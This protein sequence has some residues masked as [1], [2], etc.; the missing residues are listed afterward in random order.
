MAQGSTTTPPKSI[1]M[2]L[3][4]GHAAQV[5]AAVLQN[6]T[7]DGRREGKVELMKMAR[8]ADLAIEQEKVIGQMQARITN[9][10]LRNRLA[11]EL[12]ERLVQLDA[13]TEDRYRASSDLIQS[14][15]ELVKLAKAAS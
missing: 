13:S 5:I 7:A 12:V 3:T 15:R 6:G 4:W 2:R 8:A 9:L 1:D 10:E 11:V 14:A